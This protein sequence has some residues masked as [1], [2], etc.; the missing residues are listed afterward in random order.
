MTWCSGRSSF[1]ERGTGGEKRVGRR[2]VSPRAGGHEAVDRR[3]LVDGAVREQPGG[4]L[5]VAVQLGQRVRRGAIG[6]AARDVSAVRD[7]SV[8]HRH[9]PSAGGDV[10]RRLA[11]GAPGKIRVGAVIQQPPRADWRVGPQQHVHQWRHAAG[12]PVHVQPITVQ[13]LERLRSPPPLVI[14]DVT[15]SVGFAPA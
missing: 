11:V 14:C 13:Q 4:D 6:A 7:E 10:Q 5:G 9:V 1:A 3:Q 12:N 2:A 15:P 8:H